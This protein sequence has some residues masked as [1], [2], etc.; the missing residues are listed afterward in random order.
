M[1]F[2]T[3]TVRKP[4]TA[5]FK[6]KVLAAVHA[7][8]VATGVPDTD[9]FQRVLELDPG[10]FRYDT[11]YPDVQTT[12]TDDFALI[13]IVWSVGRSVKVKKKLLADLMDRLRADGFDPENVMVV[14]KETNW[15]NWSFAGGR[16]L[17]T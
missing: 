15:E 17:H 16:L 9:R 12:R 10:D 6:D 11:H 2:V 3:L 13:E 1:P 7:A 5:E 8:L 14:F 4:K